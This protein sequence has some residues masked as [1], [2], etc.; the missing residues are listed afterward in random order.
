VGLVRH[1]VGLHEDL[2]SCCVRAC[3]KMREG[4]GE[5]SVRTYSMQWLDDVV[6][7]YKTLFPYSRQSAHTKEG[8]AQ[9]HLR[10]DG[11]HHHEPLSR[12]DRHTLLRSTNRLS[13]EL[14]GFQAS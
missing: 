6:Q 3:V 10:N 1:R 13:C 2:W 5:G 9:T 8:G 11:K 7:I 14:P 4:E 12:I